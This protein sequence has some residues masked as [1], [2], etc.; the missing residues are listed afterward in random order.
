MLWQYRFFNS[1]YVFSKLFI[2]VFENNLFQWNLYFVVK[3]FKITVENFSLQTL[4]M[5]IFLL[6]F[7][8]QFVELLI[9]CYTYLLLF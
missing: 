2:F 9:Q 7:S 1:F 5:I 8:R 3:I 6:L 4:F